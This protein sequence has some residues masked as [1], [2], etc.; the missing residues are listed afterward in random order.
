MNELQT[1]DGTL[2][3]EYKFIKSLLTSLLCLPSRVDL[4]ISPIS[5]KLYLF[6]ELSSNWSQGDLVNLLD[7]VLLLL[8]RFVALGELS[9]V[10]HL[11]KLSLHAGFWCARI[12]C[13]CTPDLA[14]LS[15]SHFEKDGRKLIFDECTF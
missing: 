15:R 5:A 7:P 10:L 9:R 11:T 1:Q 12:L 8:D 6:W 3:G 14:A 4:E 2:Y 13:L